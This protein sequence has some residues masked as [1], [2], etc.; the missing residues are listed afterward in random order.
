[1]KLT[2]I[3]IA[4]LVC[5]FLY[6]LVFERDRLTAFASGEAQNTDTPQA[7]AGITP[8]PADKALVSVIALKSTA[9][10]VESAILLRGRTQAA[11]QVSV[12]AETSGKVI[13]EPL[14]KGSQIKAGQILCQLDPGT[15]AA[16]LAQAKAQLIGAEAML[17]ESKA[18]IASAKAQLAGANA[19]LAQAQ[20][21]ENAARR[22]KEGGFASKTRLASATAALQRAL[23][24]IQAANTAEQA[25]K[26]AVQ[27]ASA[28]IQAAKA[29]VASIEKD[30]G[31]LSIHAPFDGF[32]ETDSAQLGSLLQPGAACATIIQLDPIKLV[33]FAPESQ[34]ENLALGMHAGARMAT[35]R[36]V[37]GKVTFLSKSADP[38]TRTFRVEVEIP[39]PDLA[40][41][42]GQSVEIAVLKSG[43]AAHFLPQSALTL[44]NNGVLGVRFVGQN[45]IVDFAPV[46]IVKDNRQGVWVAGLPD[47]ISVIT[48]GHKYVIKGVKVNVTYREIKP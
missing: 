38:R 10:P 29:A 31:N 34:I 12:M 9:K 18:R 32:L 45:N 17:P 16:S 7:D 21:N 14:R 35:G 11:R 24:G 39:N 40:I 30:I 8:A 27:S 44:N 19:D 42:D 43:T 13:S 33:G 6:L 23:S 1:M 2:H 36:E 47:E 20:I 46:S 25:A 26:T 15:R 5:G 37:S 41:R 28:N 22:L 3:I 4:L 48:A